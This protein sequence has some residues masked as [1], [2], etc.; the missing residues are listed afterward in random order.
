ME[1]YRGVL[2]SFRP[3]E[4][5]FVF[6]PFKKHHGPCGVPVFDFT[7]WPFLQCCIQWLQCLPEALQV[8]FK[9]NKQVGVDGFCMV[10]RLCVFLLVCLLP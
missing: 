4:I 7:L 3:V 1:G 6:N 5:V 2:S 8:L 9:P 10:V